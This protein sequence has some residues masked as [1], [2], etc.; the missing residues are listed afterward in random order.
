MWRVIDWT[1]GTYAVARFDESNQ[2]REYAGY[3]ADRKFIVHVYHSLKCAG[4]RAEQENAADKRE[5]ALKILR[6]R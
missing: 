5:D 3:E 1:N 2:K 4:W 6:G